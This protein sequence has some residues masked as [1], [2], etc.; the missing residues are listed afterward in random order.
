MIKMSEQFDIKK[1][2]D[3]GGMVWFKAFKTLLVIGMILTV[4]WALYIAFVKPHYNP[5]RTTSQRAE[6]IVNPTYAPKP[7]FGCAS[8]RVYEYY[9]RQKD[10]ANERKQ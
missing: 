5:I 8:M 10:K 9:Q 2:F 3:L 4:L 7:T 1:A 6:Q